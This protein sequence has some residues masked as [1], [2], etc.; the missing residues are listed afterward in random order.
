MRIYD[1][2]ATQLELSYVARDDRG[3]GAPAGMARLRA[4][5]RMSMGIFIYVI[6]SQLISCE[7][8]TIMDRAG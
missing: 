2:V 8:N 6:I 5:R 7:I 1:P 3:G 4:G